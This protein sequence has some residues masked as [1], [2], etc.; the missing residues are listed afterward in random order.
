MERPLTAILV[1]AAA[2]GLAGTLAAPVQAATSASPAK[3]QM[4]Q[5]VSSVRYREGGL[6]VT[7]LKY[8]AGVRPSNVSPGPCSIN[9]SV[10]FGVD[11]NNEYEVYCFDGHGQSNINLYSVQTVFSYQNTSGEYDHGTNN[12]APCDRVQDFGEYA[13]FQ[14]SPL[15]HVCWLELA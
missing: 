12:G 4:A 10:G 3:H 6:R 8:A 15:A 1:M 2:V 9:S 11:D 14:Y 7:V 5:P 13:F